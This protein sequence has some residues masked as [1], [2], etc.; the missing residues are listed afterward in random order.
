MANQEL[1]SDEEWL[2]LKPK[3]H[4]SVKKFRGNAEIL[5]NAWGALLVGIQMGWRVSFIMHNQGTIK[6]YEKLTGVK[7]RDVCKPETDLSKK[8]LGYSIAKK[9][10]S[11]W[12]AFRGEESIQDRTELIPY[13]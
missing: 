2:K 8:S 3:L 10:S 1:I 4:E 12:K 13:R 5:E 9:L 7:F 6:K 11:I